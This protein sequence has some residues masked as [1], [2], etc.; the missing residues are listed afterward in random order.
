MARFTGTL[1]RVLI[2]TS[3]QEIWQPGLIVSLTASFGITFLIGAPRE[4]GREQS[5]ADASINGLI[6]SYPNAAFIGM[7]LSLA[8]FGAKGITATSIASILTVDKR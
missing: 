2:D 5:R 4:R 8:V 7:P 3:W 6:A 1:F